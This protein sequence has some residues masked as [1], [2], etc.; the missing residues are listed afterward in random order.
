MA[1]MGLDS[2]SIFSDSIL[3]GKVA[4]ITGGGTGIGR[5]IATYYVK[6]GAKVALMG[7]RRHVLDETAAELASQGFTAIAVDGDVKK[8]EDA[9]RVVQ[10]VFQKLGRLDIL[11]NG[12]AGNFLS[13]AE[14]LSGN[15]LRA[16][17]EV[18]TIGAYT[19]SHASLH[20]LKRGGQ[21]KK[22]EELG[23]CILNISATV[24]YAA[25]WYQTHLSAAKSANDSLTRSLALEWGTDFGIRVN[26]LSPG[27][28]SDTPGMTKL[29]Y[30][31]GAKD[32]T[33]EE[34]YKKI[35]PLGGMGEKW[36]VSMAAIY[37]ASDAAKYVNGATLAVDGG[38][39]LGQPRRVSH[40]TIRQF[41]REYEQS[42]KAALKS[43][44]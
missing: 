3:Q 40:E 13:A 36:D 9:T 34:P 37:L 42:R 14:D 29:C 7:R 24:Q 30:I 11:I 28:I 39:W 23:G 12:A 5:N 20:Y 21:G 1:E 10:T 31:F 38:L 25:L 22:P 18:D 33:D 2:K 41:S 44:L 27:T 8:K 32:P 15:G 35:V 43:K 16:V 17:L 19:M 6:H 4:L 26:N